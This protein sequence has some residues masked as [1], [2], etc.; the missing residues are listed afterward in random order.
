MLEHELVSFIRD[1]LNK[2][3]NPVKQ[4][5]IQQKKQAEVNTWFQQIIDAGII[6]VLEAELKSHKHLITGEPMNEA[7]AKRFREFKKFAMAKLAEPNL[8][9]QH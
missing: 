5:K 7:E 1:S 2:N 9:L 3:I 6:K 4:T 8:S